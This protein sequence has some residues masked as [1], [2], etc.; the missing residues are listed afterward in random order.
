MTDTTKPTAKSTTLAARL[1]HV[2]PCELKAARF[3]WCDAAEGSRRIC[4]SCKRRSAVRAFCESIARETREAAVRECE[5]RAGRDLTEP[6][7]GSPAWS[8]WH[9]RTDAAKQIALLLT[10]PDEQ[11]EET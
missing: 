1:D 8:Y 4:T 10:P 9:G 6:P 5:T 2:M 11:R 7:E 3:M